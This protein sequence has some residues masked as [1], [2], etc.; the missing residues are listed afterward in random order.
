MAS[1]KP[2]RHLSLKW[3][4]ET[5]PKGELLALV[6]QGAGRRGAHRGNSRKLGNV[7]SRHGVPADGFAK[8]PDNLV[9]FDKHGH[10]I[11]RLD[12]IALGI[13][14][15]QLDLL[16]EGFRL[17]A[18]GDLDSRPFHISVRRYG[19]RH[20]QVY[21]DLERLMGSGR[22]DAA[23]QAREYGEND[24]RTSAKDPHERTTAKHHWKLPLY[25]ECLFT[26]M[27]GKP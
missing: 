4:N 7:V 6:H 17:H 26:W 23:D 3:I 11:G 2:G 20:G 14:Q 8:N 24:Q 18:P 16:A 15:Q 21:P 10:G 5:G 22:G 25:V 1:R 19:S 27:D 12:L 13:H 9:S